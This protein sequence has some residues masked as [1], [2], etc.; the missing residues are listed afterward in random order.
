MKV[1]LYKQIGDYLIPSEDGEVIVVVDNFMVKAYRRGTSEELKNIKFKLLGEEFKYLNKIKELKGLVGTEI[2][3]NYAL[4]FP[5]L[6]TRILK[7]NQIIGFLFEEYVYTTLSKYFKVERQKEIYVPTKLFHVHNKP[8]FIVEGKIAIEAKTGDYNYAQILDYEMKY[9]LG[10]IVFPYSG[11]C[12]VKRWRCFFN[13]I[14]DHQRVI[15]WIRY[16]LG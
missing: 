3:E 12:K 15:N 1:F 16:L 6:R 9:P 2:D 10:A 8:D 4:A 11:I 7:L 14:K 13:F 5:D